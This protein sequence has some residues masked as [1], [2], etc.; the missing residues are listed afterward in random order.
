MTKPDYA[1]KIAPTVA[2]DIVDEWTNACWDAVELTFGKDKVYVIIH[3]KGATDHLQYVQR[4]LLNK[5][6]A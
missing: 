1:S 3:G 2:Q 4:V 5:P 6:R